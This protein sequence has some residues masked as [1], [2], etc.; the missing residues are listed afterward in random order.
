MFSGVVSGSSIVIKSFSDS[1]LLEL[2]N[3]AGAAVVSNWWMRWSL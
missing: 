1:G 3:A 2:A